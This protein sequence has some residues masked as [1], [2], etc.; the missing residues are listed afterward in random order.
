MIVLV[1][2]SNTASAG[3]EQDAVIHALS[4]RDPVTCASVEALTPTPVDT[5]RTVVK[6]VSMPPWVPMRAAQCLVEGHGSEVR[7][8]L[9]QWV[10]DPEEQGLGLLVLDEIDRLP[11]DLALEVAK[12]ALARGPDHAAA[13]Q[14]VGRATSP[15]LK[16]LVK[17]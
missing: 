7:A 5:L 8:E 3:P 1:G 11:Q 2:L 14:R 12:T 13:A 4:S 17:P 16:A 15:Q 10:V 9:L 6:V